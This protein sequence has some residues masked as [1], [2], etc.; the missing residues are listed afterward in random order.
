MINMV[1]VK[2]KSG[3]H[4]VVICA[5]CTRVGRHSD[6]VSVSGRSDQKSHRPNGQL[7]GTH[8]QSF[9]FSFS[10]FLNKNDQQKRKKLLTGDQRNDLIS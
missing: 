7:P 1:G 9:R 6:W 4:F 8:P 3:A 2:E 5:I 10:L